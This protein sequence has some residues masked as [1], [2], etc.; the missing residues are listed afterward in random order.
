MIVGDGI[1]VGVPGSG[2]ALGVGV[3][4][5]VVV[6]DGVTVTVRVAVAV[7]VGV[8]VTE[9]M[10]VGV[11]VLVS[12]TVGVRVG[13]ALGV[14]VGVAGGWLA[15][16]AWRGVPLMGSPLASCPLRVTLS[17]PA[18]LASVSGVCGSIRSIEA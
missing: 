9:G 1:T 10:G 3:G 7:T 12:V 5:G 14:T 11:R 13:V 17:L 8:G 15:E 16:L 2:V 4:D 6:L 18:Q